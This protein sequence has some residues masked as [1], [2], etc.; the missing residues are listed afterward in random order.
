VIFDH[1]GD[2]TEPPLIGID[3]NHALIEEIRQLARERGFAGGTS[4]SP[5]RGGTTARTSDDPSGAP[6]AFSQNKRLGRGISILDS[7]PVWGRAGRHRF[8]AEHFRAIRQAGF[9]H[10]RINLHPFGDNPTSEGGKAS[11]SWLRTLGWAI[12]E[13]LAEGLLVILDF[14]EWEQMSEDPENLKPRFLAMW[15]Q[16]AKR[17]RSRPDSVLFEILN[18]PH[19]KLTAELWN[20]LLNEALTIIRL[21]NPTRSII[22]GPT[23]YYSIDQLGDLRIPPED[24]NIL[25][26]IHY[27]QPVQFT[28]Q[29]EAWANLRDKIGVPW[30]GT[31]E[32]QDQIR[33]DFDKAQAWAKNEQRPLYLG[34]FGASRNADIPSR[35]RYLG[36]VAKE[37]ERREWSWAYYNFDC[38][39][40][41]LYDIPGKHWIQPIRDALV[42]RS[43]P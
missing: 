10:V 6:D 25:V 30:R 28:L 20:Q 41:V 23:G 11:E 40:Y 3:K 33:R 15:A 35:V 18:E 19:A 16:I 36:F 7:D 5:S 9:N 31:L 2:A 26:T 27:Y 39:N 17:C 13:A 42:R 37:A 34:E 12:D 38:G 14:H 4:G 24:R 29:G 21:T 8:R 22:I 32:E 1:Y 43:G